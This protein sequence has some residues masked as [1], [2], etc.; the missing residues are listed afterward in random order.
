[1]PSLPAQ[2]PCTR[3]S[4]LHGFRSVAFMRALL[5]SVCLL[6]TGTL[7]PSGMVWATGSVSA[8]PPGPFW[9]R[10]G[11]SHWIAQ[12]HGKKVVYDIL[13]PNCPYC[14]LLYNELQPDIG[15]LGLQVRYIVVGFLSASSPDKAASI[16]EAPDPLAALQK[17]EQGFSRSH[18][19]GISGTLPTPRSRREMAQNLNLLK[20]SGQKL[21]PTMVYRDRRGRIQ[22]IH[23]ALG[24]H[25]L[26][27]VLT[28]AGD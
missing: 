11:E 25:S 23:G 17:N 2:E 5:A 14:H 12:G 26:R 10:L 7:L 24:S 19:G 3:S 28:G 4:G 8:H 9:K 18:Y 21:V 1:M 15:R 22:I 16:L 20:A 13:D 27:Q 6:V